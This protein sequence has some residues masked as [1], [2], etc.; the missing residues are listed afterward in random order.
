MK[1][2]DEIAVAYRLDGS[3]TTTGP[4]YTIT[5]GKVYATTAI[6]SASLGTAVF[7]NKIADL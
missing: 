3:L 7:M 1:I 6:G 4:Y 5:S 2:S